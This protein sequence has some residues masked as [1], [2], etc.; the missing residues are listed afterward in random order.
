MVWNNPVFRVKLTAYSVNWNS[1]WPTCINEPTTMW[2]KG[3]F[4][5]PKRW[6]SPCQL[7]QKV[8]YSIPKKGHNK[9]LKKWPVQITFSLITEWFDLFSGED[10]VG[11]VSSPME[12]K[13][14]MVSSWKFR[15][16]PRWTSTFLEVKILDG[17]K[18]QGWFR[19]SWICVV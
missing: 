6:W 13:T 18:H 12:V 8:T 1:P 11:T 17:L 2:F 3:T 5:S 7:F 19:K 9:N 14:Y 16:K 15:R 10:F 4:L